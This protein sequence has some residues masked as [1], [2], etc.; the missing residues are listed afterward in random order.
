MYCASIRH[1]SGSGVHYQTG[2]TTQG[3]DSETRKKVLGAG[4]WGGGRGGCVV[5]GK[6]T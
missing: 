5:G 2:V 1:K 3:A 4:D 6:D